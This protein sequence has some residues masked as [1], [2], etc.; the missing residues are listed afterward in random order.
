MCRVRNL[1]SPAPCQ[2]PSRTGNVEPHPPTP[3]EPLQTL[4]GR[5]LRRLRNERGFSRQLVATRLRVTP[6]DVAAH[7]RGARRFTAEELLA[8]TRVFNI[9]ISDLFR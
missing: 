1:R 5:Q 3:G 2:T 6:A 7:E 9:R 4:L 8:Y